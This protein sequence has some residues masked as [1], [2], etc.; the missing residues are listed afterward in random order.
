MKRLGIIV[1]IGLL[2][3]CSTTPPD[4]QSGKLKVVATTNIVGDV[5]AQ[6]G[7]EAIDLTVMLPLG[8]DPH[9]FQPTPQDLVRIAEADIIFINGL[10]LETFL[11]EMVESTA[12]DAEVVEVSMGIGAI[13]AEEHHDEEEGEEEEHGEF[14]PH[15]WM[16]VTNVMIWTD[17]T[18]AALSARDPENAA[19][20]AANAAAYRDELDALDAWIM[21][22]V[23]QLTEEQR[24]L[25]TDHDSFAYFAQ[26]YGFTI[27]GAV[28]PSVTTLA[29]PSAQELAE[30][31]EAIAAFNVPAIFVETTVSP[32][33]AE[34]VA[35]DTGIQVITL[36]G[37]SL[38]AAD[39]PAATYLD[40]MRYDVM[41]IV[42]ALGGD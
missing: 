4:A 24:V 7:G 28:F 35:A 41:V 6:I 29:E 27:V 9:G 36:Y 12:T 37:G 31:E 11:A 33:L 8:A 23:G 42:E 38:S 16:D 17:N 39:G 13:A 10:G 18:A 14:D 32:R 34:Q 26:R 19:T 15:V 2:A 1:L 20:Y 40:M 22:Q 5:V 25:V 30:L 3:A 21:E